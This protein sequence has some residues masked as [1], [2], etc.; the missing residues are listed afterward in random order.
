MAKL[1][2]QFT[3]ARATGGDYLLSIDT[4]DGETLE[5]EA[6]YEQLDLMVEALDEQL[7]SDEDDTLGVDED[8]DEDEVDPAAPAD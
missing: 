3:I 5:F 1:L 6:S 7:N 2:T 4:D 8:E